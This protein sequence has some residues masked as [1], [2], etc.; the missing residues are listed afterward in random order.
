MVPPLRVDT[1]DFALPAL[2]CVCDLGSRN[3]RR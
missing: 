1:C 3:L 2:F